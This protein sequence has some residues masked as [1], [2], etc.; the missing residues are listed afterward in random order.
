MYTARRV[1]PVLRAASAGG[2]RRTKVSSAADHHRRGTPPDGGMPSKA[3]F[4]RTAFQ[5]RPVSRATSRSGSMPSS[6]SS[7]LVQC[8]FLAN[9]AATGV[10]SGAPVRGVTWASIIETVAPK[11]LYPGKIG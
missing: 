9:M 5:V 6:R 2:S 3:R 11:G 4:R 8:G 10:I 1:R 7:P